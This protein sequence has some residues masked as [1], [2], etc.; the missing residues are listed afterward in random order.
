LTVLVD[1]TTLGAAIGLKGTFVA[2]TGQTDLP[3][4]P[5]RVLVTAAL[6]YANGDVHLGHLAGAYLPSDI[7]AR[8]LRA[9]GTDVAFICGSDEHG[10][11]IT[12]TAEKEGVSPQAIID[13]YHAANAEAFASARVDFDIYHRTSDPRHHEL[14]REY[15]LRLLERGHVQKKE[16][17]QLYCS[18]CARF[19]PDRYVEGRCHHCGAEGA[20]GDQCDACGRVIDA[21]Q[22]GA[23]VCKIC[24]SAPEA[25]G[26]THWF[27]ALSNFGEGLRAWLDSHPDWRPN[28]LQ[29]ARGWLNE[30]LRDRAIT[31]DLSWGVAVPL[32][33]AQGKVLYVWFDAPIGYVT[34]TQ[35]WA[36]RAGS[37]DRWRAFWCDPKTPVIHFIGKDNIP[38]HAITWPAMVM[39]VDNGTQLP[40]YVVANEFLNFGAGKKFSKS[41]GRIIR[42]RDC[43]REFGSDALRYYL[44]SIA[45]ES[46]DTEFTWE[47]F[48]ARYHELADVLGNFCH[49]G[50]SFARKWFEGKIPAAVE[51]SGADRALV[52][53]VRRARDAAGSELS[54]FRFKQGLAQ[55]MDLARAGNRHFDERRPWETRKTNRDDCAAAI[56]ASLSVVRGLGVLMWPFLPHAAEQL[57]RSLGEAAAPLGAGSWDRLGAEAA[58]EGARLGEPIVLFPKLADDEFASRIEKVT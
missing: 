52:E 21:L 49:R 39:G 2:P 14:T 55:V 6:P 5:A 47:D 45:P 44:T 1:H 38:F 57:A 13:R 7:H 28:V 18:T 30:G 48:Q 46:A 31:R 50:L 34:F 35:I 9:R 58:P 8:Y 24:A 43:A 54:R 40:S 10:V 23:P 19:L 56:A 53:A 36:A 22:L 12:V 51:P 11:P 25:R 26:T 32:E 16:T 37:P 33:E 41:L 17:Q 20:R 42:I 27:L 29:G 15:F 3:A 4:A